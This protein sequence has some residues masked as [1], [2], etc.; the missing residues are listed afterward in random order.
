MHEQEFS[1]L[2]DFVF[3]SSFREWLLDNNS[4]HKLYW[5]KWIKDHPDKVQLLNYAKGIVYALTVNH[6]QLSETEIENE[7]K[8]I[9]KKTS[10]LPAAKGTRMD[11]PPENEHLT[12]VF[13]KL[14]MAATVIG[15]AILSVIYLEHRTPTQGQQVAVDR[16]PTPNASSQVEVNNGSD[17][18]HLVRLPDGSNVRL[19]PKST[20][21]YSSNS[22]GK[23]RELQLTGEAFFDVRKNSSLP[24]VVY[25]KNLVTKVL[26]TTFYVKAY[27]LDNRASVSVRTGKVSVYRKENFS[28][29]TTL[30]NTLDGLIVIPNQQV[31]YDVAN[32]Q[33]RKTIIEEPVVLVPDVPQTFVFNS[34]PLKEVFKTLQN[35]YGITIIYDESVINS[36]SLSAS[37]GEESFYEKLQLICKAINATYESIDGTIYISSQ[38]CH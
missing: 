28:D 15:I 6:R 22:F 25:T 5:E 2:E 38:S 14:A 1:T 4:E 21:V 16:K 35:A 20:I 29:K 9:M 36:C 12:R 30:A 37:M 24:F 23:K 13:K 19:Y 11:N 7:I 17:T 8:A 27:P 33:L 34:T 32:N 18:I 31:I 26:G 10:S 3:N